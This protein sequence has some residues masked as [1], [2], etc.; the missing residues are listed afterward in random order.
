MTARQI[1]AVAGGS[2]DEDVRVEADLGVGAVVVT[3]SSPAFCAGADLGLLAGPGRDDLRQIYEGFLS[4]AGQDPADSLSEMHNAVH[5]WVDGDMGPGTSPND[6]VFFLH[7][8]NVDV[9]GFRYGC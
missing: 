7:H 3:G 5:I 8:A 6:P 1:D 2:V 9:R 4:V